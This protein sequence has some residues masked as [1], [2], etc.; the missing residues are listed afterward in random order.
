MELDAVEASAGVHEEEQEARADERRGDGDEEGQEFL[1][2]LGSL[3]EEG[4]LQL[5]ISL[6]FEVSVGLVVLNGV[7]FGSR[8]CTVI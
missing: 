4:H 7:L 3:G 6:L 5:R 2:G 8:P 1:A